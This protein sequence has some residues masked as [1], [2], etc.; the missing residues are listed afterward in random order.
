MKKLIAILA[1]LLPL[2]VG[3]QKS[4]VTCT[5]N[6][7]ADARVVV[8]EARGGRFVP[9]DTLTPDAKGRIKVEKATADPVM[10]VLGLMQSDSP[11]LHVMLLPRENITMEVDFMPA[12]NFMNITSVS[13]SDNMKLYKEYTNMVTTL[14]LDQQTDLLPKRMESLIEGRPDVLMSAFLVTFFEQ[15]FEQYAP[16]YM[17]VRDALIGRW[18]DNE[19]VKHI[20]GR[21]RSVL[22]AGMDAPDIVMADPDGKE[23]KLSDLQGKVVLV[24]FWASW[25]RPCRMENPNVVRLYQKFH[26]KGFEVFSVSLDKDYDS[27]VRAI[28]DD[29]LVWENHV[30]DLKYWSS[31]AGRLYG[32]ASIPST[33]LVGPD[34]K[35]LARNLRGRELENKLEEIFNE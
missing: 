21:L 31:A 12:L 13:G 17:K 1:V 2:A 7:L 9:F 10:L 16:L 29:G 22:V 34:G 4:S 11:V 14:L 30:S 6:G 20:D 5:F 33:V 28:K 27:W 19:F 18:A 24:D 26:D 8:A 32:I 15:Q 25:C 3:A 35:I 23:R